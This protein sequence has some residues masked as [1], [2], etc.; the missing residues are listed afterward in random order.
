MKLIPNWSKK[1]LTCHFCGETRSVK[2]E[3]EIHDFT[4]DIHKTV[5]ACNKCALSRNKLEVK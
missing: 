1:K 2:Y 5:C 3:L 4:S